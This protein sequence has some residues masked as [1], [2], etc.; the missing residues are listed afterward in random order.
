MESKYSLSEVYFGN[1]EIFRKSSH[2]LT[3]LFEALFH[4]KNTAEDTY[5]LLFCMSIAY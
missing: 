1:V 3:D 2:Q 5:S 4:S